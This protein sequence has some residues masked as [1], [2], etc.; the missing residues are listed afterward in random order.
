MYNES[1]EKFAV[2]Q[3]DITQEKMKEMPPART[4]PAT[5]SAQGI[6]NR[7]KDFLTKQIVDL[8]F[9]NIQGLYQ[10]TIMFRII[11][12]IAG[13]ILT[14]GFRVS[15]GDDAADELCRK[16]VRRWP[17][18]NQKNSIR[19]YFVYGNSFDYISWAQDG[20]NIV[21]IE[22]MDINYIKD[23]YND[24]GFLDHWEYVNSDNKFQP[25][26]ILHMTHARAKGKI[27][28]M[29]LLAPAAATLGLLLNSNTNV[30]ILIDRYAMPIVQW[31]LDSGIQTPTG[32]SKKVSEEQIEAFA[33]SL[34]KQKT[35]EDIITDVSVGFK[36]M[37]LDGS[38][39]S[40]DEAVN[41]LNEQFHAICG[42][43]A[44]LLGYGGTNK[45]IST[46]QMKMYYDTIM[47]EQENI[48]SQWASSL[49]EP[50]LWVN[51]Y[52]D[53]DIKVQFQYN[54]IEERSERIIWAKEMRATGDITKG[55]YREVMGFPHDMPEETQEEMIP[56]GA[57][58]RD[59]NNR[60]IPNL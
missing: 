55:E 4:L 23:K 3:A 51:G 24:D 54:E 16:V 40:F 34:A 30:A 50:Y 39:W 58:Q 59:V 26:E 20:K 10:G 45:E 57:L 9:E 35:G 17:V 21:G 13:D 7:H 11:E 33:R 18:T 47:G 52:K 14:G 38:G 48:G 6:F 25:Y 5:G 44:M 19:D 41:F 15:T 49:F 22:E 43:P 37:G 8:T 12:K 46:R 29:S 1:M 56:K 42:V 32:K 27:F 28:G 60:N 2:N 31:L 53:L 36:I